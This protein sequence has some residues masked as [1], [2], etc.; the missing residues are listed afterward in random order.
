MLLPIIIQL[1]LLAVCFSAQPQIIWVSIWSGLTQRAGRSKKVSVDPNP[2]A[3]QAS[4]PRCAHEV[5]EA[6][7]VQW[8]SVRRC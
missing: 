1:S 4:T 8:R 3:A 7:W 6:E 5:P 2:P